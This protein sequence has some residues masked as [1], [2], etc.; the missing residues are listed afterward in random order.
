ME[1]LIRELRAMTE[2]QA[3]SSQQLSG[4]ILAV[5]VRFKDL[6]DARMAGIQALATAIALQPEL[7]AQKLHDDFVHGLRAHFETVRNIP[8][9]LKDVATAIKLAASDLR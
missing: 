9:E 1:T 3:V 2:K 4:A 8:Q 7:D 5:C 6:L